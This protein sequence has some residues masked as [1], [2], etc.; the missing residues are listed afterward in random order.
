MYLK[1]KLLVCAITMV[2]TIVTV[3]AKVVSFVRENNGI[4]CTLEKGLMSVKIC[5]DN[6]V[7]VKYTSLPVFL[8]KPSL[9]VT[10]E[11]KN[12]PGF[13]VNEDQDE[14]VITTFQSDYT[15]EF[16]YCTLKT[17]LVDRF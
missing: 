4:T 14:I 13:S 12:I 3:Q 7:E 11:W 2:V 16:C 6:M 9:V 8:D 10:N 1:P 17:F 15:S 5:M